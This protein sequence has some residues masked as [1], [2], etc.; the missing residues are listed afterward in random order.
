MK[1]LML[2][3]IVVLVFNM[4]ILMG[5]TLIV[6]GDDATADVNTKADVIAV[7]IIPGVP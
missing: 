6:I 2:A 4:I 3:Y 1:W 7:P 5:C